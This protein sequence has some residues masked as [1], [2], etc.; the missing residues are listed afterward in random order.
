MNHS[1]RRWAEQVANP[2]SA[3]TSHSSRLLRL[4]A[5]HF[6]VV[7]GARCYLCRNP[8]RPGIANRRDP[9]SVG[10]GCSMDFVHVCSRLC[11]HW[12]LDLGS[13]VWS[14]W[15]LQIRQDQRLSG[16]AHSLL[17]SGSLLFVEDHSCSPS[18]LYRPYH[19]RCRV[20]PGNGG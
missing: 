16:M 14:R 3:Q 5:D 9:I 7:L 4:V 20:R 2:G 15:F 18:P 1:N 11:R 6:V 8:S 10:Q 12:N 19:Q 17:T 13:R